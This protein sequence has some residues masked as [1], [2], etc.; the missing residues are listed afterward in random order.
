MDYMSITAYIPRASEKRITREK[1]RGFTGGDD[2][3]NLKAMEE[4]RRAG[5]P[6]AFSSCGKGY[7]IVKTQENI[8]DIWECICS[9]INTCWTP[10]KPLRT[11]GQ[12]TL[13]ELEEL[14]TLKTEVLKNARQNN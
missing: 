12:M 5:I 3:N 10:K 1:L 7:Y 9:L 11:E 6:V 14:I 2:Q 8:G 13:Y 4:A